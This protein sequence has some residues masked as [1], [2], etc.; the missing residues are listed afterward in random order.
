MKKNKLVVFFSIIFSLLIVE[1]I[2]SQIIFKKGN[3]NFK[4]AYM[5]FSEG[6]VFKN[7]DNFFTYEPNK[8]ITAS[9]YYFN[10]VYFTNQGTDIFVAKISAN[11]HDLL[12]ST[13]LGGSGNDGINYKTRS[14]WGTFPRKSRFCQYDKRTMQILGWEYKNVEENKIYLN[15]RLDS[16]VTKRFYY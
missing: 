8:K 2:C 12:A 14:S 10:G 6:K 9:N 7:I 15:Q 13:F 5:L 11:G 1:I 4:N 3:Y 16:K